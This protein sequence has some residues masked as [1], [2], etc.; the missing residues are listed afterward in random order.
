[1]THYLSGE[2]GGSRATVD[3]RISVLFVGSGL[4]YSTETM[5]SLQ[6]EFGVSALRCDSIEDALGAP[7]ID[8]SA[9]RL[10]VVDQ[11]LAEDLLAR[12][13]AYRQTAGE[14]CI[15]FAYRKEDAAREFRARWRRLEDGD[16]GFLPTNV[17]VEIWRSTL[18]LLLHQHL[19]I[20]MAL[21]EVAGPPELRSS[22][23]LPR[24]ETPCEE[25]RQNL[26]RRLTKREKEVLKLVA[27]GESN[28]AVAGRLGIT[29]HTVKLHMHNLV[30]K[31]GVPNRTAAASFYFEVA[32]QPERQR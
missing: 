16:I 23:P 3:D 10:L 1:M 29:E 14:G 11:R 6:F 17:P 7:G 12:P 4:H 20:P 25:P 9:L 28:K 27:R 32:G 31:I 13:G 8:L 15:A 22:P 18:R 21:V 5:N 2:P 19:H 24:S 30:N 26:F